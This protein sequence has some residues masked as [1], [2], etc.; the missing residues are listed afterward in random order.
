[1]NL[2][3]IWPQF[4]PGLKVVLSPIFGLGLPS[5][6]EKVENQE[7]YKNKVKNKAKTVAQINT[8]G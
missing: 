5:S 1:L 4:L 6:L 3:K 8:Y 7:W 2:A